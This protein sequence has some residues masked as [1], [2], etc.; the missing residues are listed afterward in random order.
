LTQEIAGQHSPISSLC[1]AEL[2]NLLYEQNDLDA[3]LQY[4]QE[5]IAMAKPW[6]YWEGLL[7]GYTGLARI[8]A[9][10]G[11]WR[12]ALSALD[13]L[14]VLGQ[15][16][17]HIKHALESFR[18]KLWALRGDLENAGRW[19]ATA[20]LDLGSEMDFSR[21]SE[22]IILVRVLIAQGA[23]DEAAG[24]AARLMETAEIGERWGHVIELLVL[25]ALVFDAMSQPT[26]AFAALSRALTLAE[27]EG[28]VRIF[29]DAGMP[30]AR[31]LYQAAERGIVPGYAGRL[32]SSLPQSDRAKRDQIEVPTSHP[33]LPM[34]EPLSEREIEVLQLIAEGYTNKEIGQML[35]LA[36]GTI[37]VHAHNIYGKLGVSGR[38]QAVAKAR[39]LGILPDG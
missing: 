32:L 35:Y 19:A 39:E 36:L 17:P 30:M 13:E 16:F 37:K 23:F 29:V 24:L 5:A 2:G 9:V 3:A 26:E 27:P 21:E 34:V 14:A 10:Q 18:A 38:T 28:Y 1:Q 4:L 7:P 11:D 15:N 12:G 6:G 25:Q 8:R 22:A 33:Q 31:L 20:K